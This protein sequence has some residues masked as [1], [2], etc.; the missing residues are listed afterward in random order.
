MNIGGARL[1]PQAPELDH[2]AHLVHKDQDDEA[3][4]ERPA[5][6]EAVGGDRDQHR[7]R[8]GQQLQLG[9]SSRIVLSFAMKATIAANDRTELPL[10]PRGLALVE[11]IAI[12][13]GGTRLEGPAE[14]GRRLRGPDGDG[15]AWGGAVE[16]VARSSKVPYNSDSSRRKRFFCR[17]YDVFRFFG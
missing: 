16:A 7:A 9:G 14:W 3:G 6:H 4:R 13:P 10:Q 5:E 12:V 8:R 2:V 15:V 17:S 1:D 11:A